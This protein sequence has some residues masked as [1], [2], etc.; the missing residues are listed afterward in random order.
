MN[1]PGTDLLAAL[2]VAVYTTNR[3]GQ[4]TYFNEAAA[5]LWGNRPELGSSQW[6]GSW[7]LFWPDGRPLAHEDCPMAVTLREGTPVRGVEAVAERPDGTRVPFMPYPNLL[8]DASGEVVGAI[9]LLVDLTAERKA[10]VDLERLASIVASSDDAIITKTLDGVITSWNA[11]ATRVYG[12]EADEMIGQPV[13]RLIPPEL[14]QEED[15]ILAKLA[16]GERIDHIET[17]R[18]TKD[19]RRLDVSLTIS[20]LRDRS[21]RIVGAS[22]VARDITERKRGEELQRL[23]FEELNH[24]VKNTLATIQ[25]IATQSLR[26]SP[27]PA[28]FVESFSGRIQA[29][30]AAHDLLVEGK[31][32]SADVPQLV[33]EQVLLGGPPDGRITTAGPPVTLTARAAVQ[34]SLVLH[35]LATN[36]RKYGALRHPGG[37]VEIEWR[38][39]EGRKRRLMIQW[40]ET[41]ASGLGKPAT[42]GFGTTLI[43]RSLQSAG[44]EATLEYQPTGITCVMRLPLAEVA[45]EGGFKARRRGIAAATEARERVVPRI[46]VVEDES[47]VAMEIEAQL[48]EAGYEVIGPAATSESARHLIAEARP[49]VALVDGNLDGHPS[50]EVAG[51]LAKRKIPFAFA[52]GYGRSGLPAAFPDT[53]ILSKPF[54]RDRLLHVVKVLL[55]EADDPGHVVSLSRTTF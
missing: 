9:N 50:D 2:P 27:N 38:R 31:M 5:K 34:L 49:D 41:G 35:E 46:L 54:S 21:G 17:V 51:E 3:E 12:Y 42:K 26:R 40:R 53:M 43:E 45:R 22:K 55:A 32:R 48:E 25:A 1:V 6:C 52:T 29:L 4:I 24:R 37:K 10:D 39:E 16:N 20:P 47:L 14:R 44:G 15:E 18:T 23:L 7:R 13:V 36:A 8:K 33:S 11:G 28:E 19:G 30:A